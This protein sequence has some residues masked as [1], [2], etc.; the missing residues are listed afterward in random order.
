MASSSDSTSC[1]VLQ[2]P[3]NFQIWK[4][5]V[6]AKLRREKVYD[7]IVPPADKKTT[8]T[9]TT[10]TTAE[11]KEPAT[12]PSSS[13][14][15][16]STLY[17]DSWETRDAKAHGIITDH[18]CDRL[19]LETASESTALALFEK[20]VE[21]HKQKNIGA[22]AFYTWVGMLGLK[23]DGDTSTLQAHIAALAS[24]DAKLTSM[25]KAIDPEFLAY[26]LLHSLPD[27]NT[28]EAFK[29]TVLNSLP[30]GATLSFAELSERLSA[31]AIHHKGTGGDSAL[32]AKT[33]KSASKKQKPQ[34]KCIHHPKVFS[35]D[36]K[37]CYVEKKLELE[38]RE[39]A[40]ASREKK[41]ESG[42]R[43]KHS[44]EPDSD[45]YSEASESSDERADLAQFSAI[46]DKK[47]VSVSKKLMTRILAYLSEH[48]EGSNPPYDK[49]L[50]SG[51][52]THMTS[53]R[54]WFA[55]DSFKPLDP[56]RRVRFG[57][58]SYVEATG[59]G[60]ITLST[61]IG[62]RTVETKLND[63]L[64][65]PSFKITLISVRRLAKAGY[66]SMFLE[67]ECIVRS[68]KSKRRVLHGTVRH[69][70][71]CLNTSPLTH[72]AHSAI[73][74]N[75]LHR[76]LGH[77]S[78]NRLKKMVNEGQIEGVDDLTGNLEFCEPCTL[79][80]IKKSPFKH[81]S[82]RAL[83]PL[84][85]VHSDVGG[86]VTPCDR[87][88]NRYWVTFIDN[89][90]RLPWVYF[91][92]KKSEVPRILKQ[93]KSDVEAFFKEELGELT[94]SA[95]FIDFFGS[96]G[97]GEYTSD[98]FER[99]LK[100][101]GI[102][103]HTTAAHTPE[104]NGLAERMNQNLTNM[105]T[106]M[107]IDS[108]LPKS[109]WTDAMSTSAFIIAR[110]PATGLKGQ[111]PYTAAFNR[112]VDASWFK[113]FG[114]PAYALIPKDKRN[115]KFGPKGIKSIFL[116]YTAG[117]KAYRL[118]DLNT[119]K[120]FH[121]RHVVFDEN[122]KQESVELGQPGAENSPG[123]NDLLRTSGNHETLRPPPKTANPNPT[124]DST[125][126]E[127]G[128]VINSMDLPVAEPVGGVNAEPVGG[129]NAEPVGGNQR[130]V[131]ERPK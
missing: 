125:N 75:V 129:A 42:H 54:E 33:Q 117:K 66:Y 2:G 60:S 84:Q 78:R 73:D 119:R 47:P 39:K 48:D 68:K 74:I 103:H 81:K 9:A 94:L 85:L 111:N 10:Q 65:I 29:S 57:D 126:E 34:K 25:K 101:M 105:A 102:I 7:T 95:N 1:P 82:T 26:M 49:I 62:T 14:L 30:K 52:S 27:D 118:L 22:S 96:D 130:P 104:Q 110:T 124:H 61:K 64:Y 20:L 35:H 32:K 5:R 4:H 53:V 50:D 106:A 36:T 67:N 37:D 40:L 45:V 127:M 89:H 123:W 19:V 113:P 17:L 76:R 56:P 97:G 108:N 88:G 72:S 51:A 46:V 120:I 6:I 121:S 93:W 83:R 18:I 116:G 59:I 109:Y 63:V 87:Y 86:P 11:G 100:S 69:G 55:C 77:L 12:K 115:G 3:E 58:E 70:L 31:T 91:M 13:P 122:G 80:K 15:S 41:Q 16:S 98:Q 114:C 24:A 79:A 92:N 107:L 90:L 44:A 131:G 8:V 99:D 43:A 71:Y 28:W 38:K 112:P 21:I 128:G 23:W